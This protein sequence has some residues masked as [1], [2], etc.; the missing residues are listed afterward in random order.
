MQRTAREVA[1]GSA[2]PVLLVPP[3]GGT[4]GHRNPR[5]PSRVGS[6][7][8]SLSIWRAMPRK[9]STSPRRLPRRTM[10]RCLPYRSSTPKKLSAYPVYAGEGMHH[11]MQGL[12]VL[13]AKRLAEVLPDVSDGP[14]YQRQVVEGEA[15]AGIIAQTAAYQADLVIVS[16]HPYG[17][18]QKL[19]T[20]ST[21][22]AMLAE[23]IMS[24]SRRA[25]SALR[26]RVGRSIALRFTSSRKGC[27]DVRLRRRRSQPLDHP[28]RTRDQEDKPNRIGQK[29]RR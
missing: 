18:I 7:C 11:N 10:P 19:F 2:T 28:A 26:A 16:A 15:A 23:V 12:K 13:L 8:Y 22:D 20:P 6:D 25:F 3:G 29:P 21:I 17:A 9:R 4:P 5:P 24:S 14:P 27:V 1:H